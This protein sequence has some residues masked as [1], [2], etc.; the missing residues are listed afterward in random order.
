[1]I[2][3]DLQET[4]LADEFASDVTVP[5]VLIMRVSKAT[6]VLSRVGLRVE[7]HTPAASAPT[8]GV[9][10]AQSVVAGERVRR[11][12]VVRLDPALGG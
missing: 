3:E 5:N 2:P 12:V 10:A 7:A 1:M 11:G 9:V 4:E 8:E 6:S